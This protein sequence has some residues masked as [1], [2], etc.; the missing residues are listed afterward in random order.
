MIPVAPGRVGLRELVDHFGG[1]LGHGAA[2]VGGLEA[3]VVIDGEPAQVTEV[4]DV[5]V[6]SERADEFR[7]FVAGCASRP[8]MMRQRIGPPPDC[9]P[10]FGPT[11]WIDLAAPSA[12]VYADGSCRGGRL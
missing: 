6:G 10:S 12:R 9:S 2:D 7:W 8:R 1:V 11:T 5:Q 4:L 3:S